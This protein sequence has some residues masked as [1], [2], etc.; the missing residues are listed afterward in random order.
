MLQL[1]LR[2]RRG[3]GDLEGS[4]G[5]DLDLLR[6][7]S[8]GRSVRL[9]LLHEFHTLDDLAWNEMSNH[10]SNTRR[11]E[12]SI[13]KTTWAPSNHE[14]T[15]VVT[16]NWEPFV[17]LPALAIDRRPG[18]VCLIL[19]FSS[20]PP[21]PLER[22]DKHTIA[23]YPRTSELLAVDRLATGAVVAGEV[24][25]LE[26]ELGDDAVEPRAGVAV[27]VLP[28]AQLAEVARGLGD[29]VVVQLEH[30]AAARRAADG[31]IE[32]RRI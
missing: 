18:L 3:F 12:A 24:A 31:D 17:F 11:K 26:H 4:A 8:R 20:T 29:D 23:E 22:R 16:K 15:T 19:K 32:L 5:S 30:D 10:V 2:F 25:A 28:S 21:T 13:P 9:D 7:L 6:K 27:P 14:V 1:Y